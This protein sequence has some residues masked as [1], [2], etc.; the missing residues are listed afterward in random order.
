MRRREAAAMAIN[1]GAESA[2]EPMLLDQKLKGGD[3]TVTEK[4]LLVVVVC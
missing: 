1:S 4:M 2:G 3:E